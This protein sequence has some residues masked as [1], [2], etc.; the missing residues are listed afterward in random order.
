MSENLSEETR[1]LFETATRE[2]LQLGASKLE[3]SHLLL[4]LIIDSGRIGE[5]LK[6]VGATEEAAREHLLKQHE[7]VS[8][9][10]KFDPTL[11]KEIETTFRRAAE[12]AFSW[13]H[14]DAGSVHVLQALLGIYDPQDPAFKLIIAMGVD[15]TA[16]KRK[17]GIVLKLQ[18]RESEQK[19]VELEEMELPELSFE[20]FTDSS[21]SP[22]TVELQVPSRKSETEPSL[23][24]DQPT[25]YLQASPEPVVEAPDFVN[26]LVETEPPEPGVKRP[27][28]PTLI[29]KFF[30]PEAQSIIER[31]RQM[32]DRNFA[33]SVGVH[34]ILLAI[35]D[36]QGTNVHNI[37]NRYFHT[38]KMREVLQEELPPGVATVSGGFFTQEAVEFLNL[39]WQTVRQWKFSKITTDIMLLRLIDDCNREFFKEFVNVKAVNILAKIPDEV[40]ILILKEIL[41]L[42]P[43][44]EGGLPT[45]CLKQQLAFESGETYGDLSG[46]TVSWQ[47]GAPAENPPVET[48]RAERTPR[49]DHP[50]HARR[51]G[52]T[53]ELSQ[54]PVPPPPGFVLND[55]DESS[56]WLQ[57]AKYEASRLN[58][59]LMGV[60]HLL[61]AILV[62]QQSEVSS[63]LRAYVYADR[64]RMA[65][66]LAVHD[67][68]D[69]ENLKE[70]RFT[71]AAKKVLDKAYAGSV[72]FSRT[73]I[74][75]QDLLWAI[76][77]YAPA[78][79]IGGIV[80]GC[81]GTSVEELK[82]RVAHHFLGGARATGG[83]PTEPE[84]TEAWS[85]SWVAASDVQTSEQAK[86]DQDQASAFNFLQSRMEQKA[87]SIYAQKGQSLTTPPAGPTSPGEAP[88]QGTPQPEAPLHSYRATA[89]SPPVQTTEH[90]QFLHGAYD[91]WPSRKDF[92]A[93]KTA[94]KLISDWFAR[95]LA[96]ILCMAE[97]LASTSKTCIDFS[98]VF[99]AI[100][101]AEDDAR[102]RKILGELVV[103]D[104]LF[105]ALKSVDA[106]KEKS[107]RAFS[108]RMLVAMEQAWKHARHLGFVAGEHLLLGIFTVLAQSE[109]DI[110]SAVEAAGNAKIDHLIS[111]LKGNIERNQESTKQIPLSPPAERVLTMAKL[112]KSYVDLSSG[113][114]LP[115]NR[116]QP[117]PS[118]VV[119][120]NVLDVLCDALDKAKECKH[121]TATAYHVA[122]ALLVKALGEQLNVSWIRREHVP[123]IQA[124][125]LDQRDVKTNVED[126]SNS[127]PRF[128]PDVRALMNGAHRQAQR[129]LDRIVDIQH[130]GLALLEWKEVSEIFDQHGMK[131]LAIKR[132]LDNCLNWSRHL[133]DADKVDGFPLDLD[134]LED[135]YMQ[136][137]L[138]PNAKGHHD[139]YIKRL[140]SRS[141][142]VLRSAGKASELFGNNE[143][144]VEHVL[145]GLL[146]E[147][148][149]VAADVL[150]A[151]GIDFHEALTK[152]MS[153]CSKGCKRH[154][155]SQK[156][157]TKSHRI[158]KSAWKFAQQ[159]KQVLVEPEHIL[160]SIVQEHEGVAYLAWSCLNLSAQETKKLLL[161]RLRGS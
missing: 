34:H 124:Y 37:F 42:Y 81:S 105:G 112:S 107:D 96:N 6:S 156:L 147:R 94:K 3:T 92:R 31:S 27:D 146:R 121:L 53:M 41:N 59:P 120:P 1:R 109:S 17:V 46:R 99:G 126:L 115:E 57:G 139:D 152:Y 74:A 131:P 133:P 5:I 26:W 40:F 10:I 48:F 78:T 15:H 88:S 39:C 108:T 52:S 9:N 77:D 154:S 80:D 84:T 127:V 135:L 153:V 61:L 68:A 76:L 47:A 100:L 29:T 72:V 50:I 151:Q 30:T 89:E 67:R 13:H 137:N 148:E 132:A 35:L 32:A 12:E 161:S 83:A 45:Q 19:P 118:M 18:P 97:T 104:T 25:S 60:Q 106:A 141:R 158:L 110:R 117:L 20:S 85:A 22:Y 33:P 95:D 7:D 98:H 87:A 54:D 21:Q 82:N 51:H 160:L 4:A 134:V 129:G 62:G 71:V 159:F 66:E 93:S 116:N 143:V 145:L 75:P 113:P 111:L 103:F 58:A 136:E 44:I 138:G 16:L 24:A 125:L 119:S 65:L 150:S 101:L 128:G 91:K 43:D 155:S 11:S 56:A 14:G 102:T 2:A 70:S 90:Q 63:F 28:V 144:A 23:V 122:H 140:S 64:L 142:Y 123:E 149:C 49:P 36:I 55:A 157:S 79:S 69:P 8:E 114:V 86:I 130:M 38:N 73:S